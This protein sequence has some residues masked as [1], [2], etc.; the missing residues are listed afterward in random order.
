MA[1]SGGNLATELSSCDPCAVGLRGTKDPYHVR[2]V[3]SSVRRPA[4]QEAGLRSPTARH[5]SDR[6]LNNKTVSHVAIRNE[7]MAGISSFKSA[8]TF[9]DFR[10]GAAF[11]VREP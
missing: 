11:T 1:G 8:T 4:G 9:G 3:A 6:S 2:P 5:P 7:G 10:D